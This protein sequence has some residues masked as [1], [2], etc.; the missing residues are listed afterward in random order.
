MKSLGKYDTEIV[1]YLLENQDKTKVYYL[2]SYYG[3]LVDNYL[4]EYEDGCYLVIYE[5]YANCWSSAHME[6]EQGIY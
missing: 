6:K 3:C 4:F 1:D 2:E 5:K